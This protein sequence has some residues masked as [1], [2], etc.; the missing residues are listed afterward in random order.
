MLCLERLNQMILEVPSTWEFYE[1]CSFWTLWRPLDR[2]ILTREGP[3][4]SQDI[5]FPRSG[6][7]QFSH[8]ERHSL[9]RESDSANRAVSPQQGEQDKG[10]PGTSLHRHVLVLLLFPEVRVYL[11]SNQRQNRHTLW[12]LLLKWFDLVKTCTGRQHE[13]LS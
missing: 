11:C 12:Q 2:I 1:S 7:M 8:R 5:N 4:L 3:S 9:T 6:L 13:R 10:R